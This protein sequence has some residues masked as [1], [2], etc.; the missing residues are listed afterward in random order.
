MVS[1]TLEVEK[2]KNCIFFSLGLILFFNLEL[3]FI[4]TS[5]AMNILIPNVMT[6]GKLTYIIYNISQPP[7][8]VVGRLLSACHG[9]F[10]CFSDD[11]IT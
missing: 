6:F 11:I 8:Q 5:Y 2:V 7:C 9:S 10:V 4:T 1:P 3:N